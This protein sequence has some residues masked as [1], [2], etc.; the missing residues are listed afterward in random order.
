MYRVMYVS[1]R[2]SAKPM[3]MVPHCECIIEDNI[4]SWWC[5]LI[6]LPSS[7][8]IKAGRGFIEKRYWR[9]CCHDSS[10]E[11]ESAWDGICNEAGL[12][13][14]KGHRSAG[15]YR[16]SMYNALPIESVQVLVETMREFER[17]NA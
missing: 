5:E 13:G 11:L 8:M 15:G 4:E 16:A 7:R 9:G 10:C 6:I 14:L 3:N 12:H 1:A 17:R 2:A